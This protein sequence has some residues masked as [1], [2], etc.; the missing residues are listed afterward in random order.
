[1][2]TPSK[3]L[4]GCPLTVLD[5]RRATILWY[6]YCFYLSPSTGRRSHAPSNKPLLRLLPSRSVVFRA[7]IR[8]LHGCSRQPGTRL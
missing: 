2:L 6:R 8:I 3:F 1:M 7:A 5:G 4:Q